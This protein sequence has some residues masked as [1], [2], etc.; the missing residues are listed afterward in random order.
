MALS[1]FFEV[2]FLAIPLPRNTSFAALHAVTGAKV[3]AAG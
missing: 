2:F 1:I 3:V